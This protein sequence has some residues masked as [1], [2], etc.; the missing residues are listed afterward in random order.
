MQDRV[1]SENNRILKPVALLTIVLWGLAEAKDVLIPLS[2]SALLAFL[3]TPGVNL[4]KRLG[5]PEGLALIFAALIFICPLSALIYEAIIQG[6]ALVR[7]VPSILEY[8]TR[9]WDL[10]VT[11]PI[12]VRLHLSETLSLSSVTRKASQTLGTGVEVALKGL[13]AFVSAGGDLVLVLVFSLLMLAS[14]QR[15]K[16]GFEAV[17]REKQLSFLSARPGALI[18]SV[19]QLIQRFLLVRLIIILFVAGVDFIILTLFG[20]S[21]SLFA[22][23]FLGVMTIVPAVGFLLG[24]IPALILAASTGMNW[25]HWVLLLAALG[26][27]SI[28]E[29]HILSPK[30][31]GRHLN[32]NL[33]MTFLGIYVGAHLWGGWGMFLSIPILGILR[34]IL[35]STQSGAAW[36]LLLSERETP[37]SS[38]K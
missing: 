23:V 17:L 20:V 26:V 18:E 27:V 32:L 5:L 12:G 33:L 38:K 36:A 31:L 7:A 16:R 10:L 15:I 14:R 29:A 4:L 37:S 2:L 3:L 13:K 6:E 11:S 25:L 24:V 9:Q 19:S 8:L 21:Y 34:I 22:A 28:I 30:L 35:N 1:G